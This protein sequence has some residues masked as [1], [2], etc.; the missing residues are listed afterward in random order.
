M[1]DELPLDSIICADN[2][3]TLAAFP[4]ESIDLVV[5]SPPYDDLRQYGGHAWDF[6]GVA[7]Q[8][9]R[10]LKPGG[11]LV[12][13]VGDQ[14]KN[15]TETGTSFRQVLFFRHLDLN[16]HDTMIWN[17]GSF[18]FPEATRYHSFFEYMFVMSKG[19]PSRVHL[20]KDSPNRWAGSKVHGTGRYAD[21][22]TRPANSVVRGLD[23]R[24]AEYGQRGN[25]WLIPNPG[26]SGRIHP[27][28][29]PSSIPRD[30]ILTW[31]NAG[32]VVLDPF[33]GSGTTAR[34]AADLGRRWIGI[35]INPDY[36]KAAGDCMAQ[37]VL[38]FVGDE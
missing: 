27:A 5:T 2:C 4:P 35:D 10:V 33:N 30:H 20:L 36:C 24:Y 32:D 31:S 28:T 13:V 3:A 22:S 26:K 29:F 25:V 6:E 11:V 23:R 16:I 21:G 37:R 14:T 15:G 8:L 9:V 17:K 19:A 34:A 12:W 18:S 38:G 7:E 1:L